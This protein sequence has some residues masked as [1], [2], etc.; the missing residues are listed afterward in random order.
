MNYVLF[1]NESKYNTLRSLINNDHGWYSNKDFVSILKKEQNRSNRMGLPISYVV[2][3][4]SRYS[5]VAS[6]AEFIYLLRKLVILISLNTEEHDIKHL[7]CTSKIGLL[8][9]DTYLSETKAF[10][11]MIYQKIYYHLQSLGMDEVSKIMRLIAI[12]PYLLNQET[13]PGKIEVKSGLTGNSILDN[14]KKEYDNYRIMFNEML[15]RYTDQNVRVSDIGAV[16][17]IA[18]N[19][20]KKIIHERW[21]TFSYTY[22]KRFFDILGAVF[23]LISFSPMILIVGIAIKLTSKG[24]VLFKQKRLG[25]LGRP[26]NFL[27]FR[28]MYTDCDSS[29]HEKYVKSL[30]NGDNEINN[31]TGKVPLYK[32]SN[33]TRITTIGKF[34]RKTSIDEIPQLI[35]VI[36]GEMSLVGPRPPLSYEVEEYKNWHYRRILEVKPGIT[37]LWQVSGRNKTTFDE[38]VKMDIQYSENWSFLLDLKILFKTVKAVLDC[39]GN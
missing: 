25:E 17:L 8:F 10:I 39:E 28:T 2:F 14:N 35:N 24:P 20:W 13:E 7:P 9:S 16:S 31:G 33:D 23:W 32:L 38:M 34:L 12:S 18:S 26:F 37:G 36:K 22:V 19:S 30:I 6:K 3:D 29:I 4:L 15:D 21:I 1:K 11:E 5:D 27:K